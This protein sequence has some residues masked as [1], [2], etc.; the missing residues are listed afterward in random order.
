[1]GLFGEV[2]AAEVPDNPF[3]VAPGT[4]PCV[5]TEAKVVP[6]KD[7]T[8]QGLAFKWVIQDEDSEYNG[9]NI[10][11][12]N[13]IYPEVTEDEVT[14]EI[15]RDQARLKMRLTQMGLS[16]EQMNNLL[17]EGGLDELIGMTAD[18]TCKETPDKNDP[19]IKYTN[20]TKVEVE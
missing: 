5:L 9:Q 16:T 11:D 7:G 14:P 2:D 8:G 12:W 4:Y 1:M 15:R 10:Q 6:K 17:E 20:I 19:D 18:V 3:Y 13:N